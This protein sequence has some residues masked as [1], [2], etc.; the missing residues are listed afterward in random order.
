MLYSV[1]FPSSWNFCDEFYTKFESICFVVFR[2][3]ILKTAKALVED[4]KTLVSGAATNQEH[5]AS[6]AQSAVMTITKLAD[7]VKHGA[8][9]LGSEQPEAQVTASDVYSELSMAGTLPFLG[10]SN[11]FM[12]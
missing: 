11:G 1:S 7:C 2:E 10:E 8:A 12:F 9:S 3:N 5:L 4:T 6:A